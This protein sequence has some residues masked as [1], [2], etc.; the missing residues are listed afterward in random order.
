[1]L[2]T[3]D[4]NGKTKEYQ[5]I[6]NDYVL[7]NSEINAG[8]VYSLVS[9]DFYDTEGNI[10]CSSDLNIS[11]KFLSNKTTLTLSTIGNENATFFEQYF[12]DNGIRLEIVEIL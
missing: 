8:S 9:M 6:L 1:M 7:I 10:I 12:A 11:I 4:F 2:K 3:E 5:V